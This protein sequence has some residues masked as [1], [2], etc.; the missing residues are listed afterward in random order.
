M[1]ENDGKIISLKERREEI[2]KLKEEFENIRSKYEEATMSLDEFVAKHID[3]TE[4]LIHTSI[5]L[6][7]SQMNCVKALHSVSEFMEKIES[8]CADS[9]HHMT[10][11]RRPGFT[12]PYT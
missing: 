11:N 10:E 12:G 7:D 5:A 2:E 9:M 4:R 3:L 8:D 1:N 6:C